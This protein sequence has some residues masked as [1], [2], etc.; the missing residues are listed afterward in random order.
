MD[1][2]LSVDR[3]NRTVVLEIDGLHLAEGAHLLAPPIRTDGFGRLWSTCG[4][5]R[6][7]YFHRTWTALDGLDDLFLLVREEHAM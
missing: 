5:L 4:D 1:S 7:P 3:E 6:A 2:G